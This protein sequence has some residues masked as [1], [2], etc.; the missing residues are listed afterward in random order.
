MESLK[1]RNIGYSLVQNV[2]TNLKPEPVPLEE[3]EY[4][5]SEIVKAL[6]ETSD[7]LNSKNTRTS[8]SNFQKRNTYFKDADLYIMK[9]GES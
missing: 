2:L 5:P 3:F 7:P 8:S 9:K 6:F 1:K 4:Q